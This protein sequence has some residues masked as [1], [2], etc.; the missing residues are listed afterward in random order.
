LSSGE[1][2]QKLKDDEKYTVR[3]KVPDNEK[4]EFIDQ[5]R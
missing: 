3:L 4:I 5:V 2:A 1:I